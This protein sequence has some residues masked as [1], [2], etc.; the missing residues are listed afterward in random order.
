MWSDKRIFKQPTVLK[1]FY[2]N[3]KGIFISFLYNATFYSKNV[4]FFK[5]ILKPFKK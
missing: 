5:T 1:Y 4:F 3:N 2:L